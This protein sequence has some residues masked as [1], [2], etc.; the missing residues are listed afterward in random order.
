MY[1]CI[2]DMQRGSF[3]SPMSFF[4][5]EPGLCARVDR[6]LCGGHRGDGSN[7]G[8]G[9]ANCEANRLE[10]MQLI[11]QWNATAVWR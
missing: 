3:K 8:S 1:L 9:M 11:Y 5:N 2:N 4:Q 6:G 10:P 7:G